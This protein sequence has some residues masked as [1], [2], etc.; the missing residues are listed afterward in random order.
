MQLGRG[1]TKGDTVAWL[2]QQK[3][4]F[5]GDLVEYGATAYAGD[6]Y[7][8]DW[9][10]TL[11]R[12]EALGAMAI[13]PGRGAALTDPAM[14]RDG[15]ATTRAFIRD[16][17]A[18]VQAG[19]AQGHDLKRVYADTDAKLR[20]TL[21]PA[22]HLR[23]LHAVRRLARL[24][25]GD[26]AP[27]SAHLDGR[28]RQGDVGGAGGWAIASNVRGGR[29]GA[30]RQRPR[31]R[32]ASRT[33][34]CSRPRPLRRQRCR[35]PAQ[36]D[37][38]L[39]ALAACACAHRRRSTPTRR[40]RCRACS[41]STPAPS[42]RRP[43]SSRCRRRPDFRRADGRPTVSAA[44]ARAGRTSS[45]ATSASRSPRSSPNHA[46]AARD[47]IEAI[48][49][50]VRGAAGGGRRARRDRARRAGGDDR[51]A[52]TTSPPRCATAMPPTTE[53]AFA[54][55]ARPDRARSRQPA[56]RA[57]ADGA[58]Q[59]RRVVRR[60]RAGRLTAA[61][62][63]PD[64]DRP[65]RPARRRSCSAST[66]EQVRVVVGDVG[67]GFGMK[68][69]AY[70]EDIVVAY[71]ARDAEAA[72]ALAGRPQRGVPLG[73]RTAATWS[74]APSSRSTATAGCWPCACTR[75]PTSAPTR[76]RSGVA[77]QLLIGP[78]VSTSIY[79]IAHDRP[80]LQ[81]G[82]HPHDADRR[83]PRRRPARGDL[84][85]RAA[86]GRGGARDEARPGRAAPRAT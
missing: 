3:I 14:C 7:F 52:P 13:V 19:V 71:A 79:D 66:Q 56:R 10:T 42:S 61:H 72:G 49:R 73:Q 68:T 65:S 80:A 78:W 51:G 26:R 47:A 83:L 31:R 28:A 45:C 59:R 21:R 38:R 4:L 24:R 60:A 41:R 85:H 57:G 81:R 37:R 53:A 11:D 17:F 29:R 44:A 39:P 86:D 6:A 64:A 55:A 40:A 70:P 18:S 22:V 63:Q 35:A 69:G 30:L 8:S 54:R 76:R 12:V 46:S 34:R 75:S 48:G 32:S 33:A 27:R 50:R 77:I 36:T 82:A 2:P 62:Q 84:H 23:A 67:G 20:P 1:H 25:R 16:L 5:S 58:A 15:I 74:A 43:A 9:P